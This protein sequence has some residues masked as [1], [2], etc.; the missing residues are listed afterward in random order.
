MIS[1]KLTDAEL[2]ILF[3]GGD[4]NALI[5]LVKR[6]H[7]VFCEKAYWLVK[8]KDLAKDIAQDCWTIIIHKIDQLSNP[9]QFKYWALRI[10]CNKSMDSLR[11]RARNEKRNVAKFIDVES[12]E[13]DFE[14]HDDLKTRLLT[15]IN[16]LSV[17]QKMIIKLFYTEDYSLKQIS[18]LLNISMGTAKS[19]LF[20]AREK[21]KKTLKHKK[22]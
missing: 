17:Q 11:I 1:E 7:K 16:D 6:W 20:Y 18:E 21:L 22:L 2:V 3:R 5:L 15:A 4:K 13:D 19:R 8:D 9:E 10:I 14:T 12:S